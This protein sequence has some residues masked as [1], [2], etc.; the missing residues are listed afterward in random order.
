[1]THTEEEPAQTMTESPPVITS[2]AIPIIQPGDMGFLNDVQIVLTIEIGRT[3]IKIRDLLNLTKDSIVDLNKSAGEPVDIYANGRLIS[4]G[5]IINANG[6][7]CVRLASIAQPV[8]EP[9]V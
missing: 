4:H 9:A 6:K 5:H 7:Y 2:N 1:M 3:Q 8:T